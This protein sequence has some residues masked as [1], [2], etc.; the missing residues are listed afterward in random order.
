MNPISPTDIRYIKLGRGGGWFESCLRNDRIELGYPQIPQEMAAAH[1]W[2]GIATRFVEELG[3]TQAAARDFVRQIRDFYELGADCLWL[4]FARGTLWW[5]FAEPEVQWIGG[6][7][8]NQGTRYRK[9]IGPWR[10]VDIRGER[11]IQSRL[12]PR[13]TR[14]AAYRSTICNVKAAEYL[15]RRING[16]EDPLVTK[17]LAAREALVTAI[18]EIIARLHPKEFELLVDLIFARSGWQ[19]TSEIGGTQ[20]DVDL[21]LE[22]IATGER[23]FVQVKATATNA[24]LRDYIQRF[25]ADGSYDRMFF[26]CHSP[27]GELSAPEDSGVMVWVGTQVAELA[28]KAGLVDWLT[29]KTA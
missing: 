24:V 1:D 13:L 21:V 17:A 22:Q 15:V 4:T 29:E 9:T 12:S 26:V 16:E 14:V 5:V 6:R 27:N 3:R 25:M 20:P 7:S 23:A 28:V 11:L 8:A 10:G 18:A 2:E 19:R